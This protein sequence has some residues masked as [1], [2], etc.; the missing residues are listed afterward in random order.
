M[1][2][3]RNSI[4]TL[5]TRYDGLIWPR[6]QVSAVAESEHSS[7]DIDTVSDHALFE[8]ARACRIDRRICA[9]NAELS[10]IKYRL[11]VID[12]CLSSFSS[13]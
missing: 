12:H 13:R 8:Q 1:A 2:T 6:R 4:R 9:I 11:T 7:F 10:E 3:R 5:K